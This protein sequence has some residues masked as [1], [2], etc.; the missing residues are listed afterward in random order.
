MHGRILSGTERSIRRMGSRQEQALALD[1][2]P[3]YGLGLSK[4]VSL[5]LS[6]LAVG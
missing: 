1:V 6:L 5:L 4:S 3:H 2:I